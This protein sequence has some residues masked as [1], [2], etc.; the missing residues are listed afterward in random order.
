MVI[1]WSIDA[2]KHLKNSLHFH[3]NN[4]QKTQNKRKHPLKNQKTKTKQKTNTGNILNIIQGIYEKSTT[5]IILN[6]DRLKAF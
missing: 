4:C 6:S 2:E 3:D 5:D 1:T